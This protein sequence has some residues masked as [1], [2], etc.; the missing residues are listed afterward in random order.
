MEMRDRGLVLV[1]LAHGSPGKMEMGHT[2]YIVVVEDGAEEED[3]EN[4]EGGSSEG[5][6]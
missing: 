1:R 5:T 3:E 6:C 2:L 4:P